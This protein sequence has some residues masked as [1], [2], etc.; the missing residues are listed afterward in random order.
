MRRFKCSLL[1]IVLICLSVTNVSFADDMFLSG[2]IVTDNSLNSD[3]LITRGEF[4]DI[5][6]KTFSGSC[7]QF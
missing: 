3:E 1:V 2:L 7:R 4:A 6:A 5:V